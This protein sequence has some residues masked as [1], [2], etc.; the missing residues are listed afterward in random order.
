MNP[1]ANKA[2]IPLSATLNMSRLSTEITQFSGWNSIN[3]PYYGKTISPLYTKN[4]ALS[5]S[6]TIFDGSGNEYVVGSTGLTKN[7]TLVMSYN[8]STFSDSTIDDCIAAAPLSSGNMEIVETATVGLYNI[9][10]GTSSTSFQIYLTGKTIAA[11]CVA[12]G[13]YVIVYTSDSNYYYWIYNG[14]TPVTGEI[15]WVYNPGTTQLSWS[16]TP[17]NVRINAALVSSTW[18]ISILS[19]SGTNITD[20]GFFDIA[21]SQTSGTYSTSWTFSGGPITTEP[22]VSVGSYGFYA[23]FIT[24][25]TSGTGYQPNFQSRTLILSLS[26]TYNKTINVYASDSAHMSKASAVVSTNLIGSISPGASSASMNISRATYADGTVVDAVNRSFVWI[27]TTG[28]DVDN[29]ELSYVY[30]IPSSYYGWKVVYTTTTVTSTAKEYS[31]NMSTYGTK[32]LNPIHTPDVIFDDGYLYNLGF[33]TGNNAL[34]G[35]IPFKCSVSSI[36]LSTSTAI[37]YSASSYYSWNFDNTSSNVYPKS[38]VKTVLDIGEGFMRSNICASL[39][40]NDPRDPSVLSVDVIVCYDSGSDQVILNP[41]VNTSYRNNAGSLFQQ[42]SFRLLYTNGVPAGISYGTEGYRGTLLSEWYS[43]SSLF[44]FEAS[45][46]SATYKNAVDGTIHRI[47]ISTAT[48]SYQYIKNRYIVI[49][50][51]SFINCYDIQTGKALHYAEDFN[52]RVLAGSTSRDDIPSTITDTIQMATGVNLNYEITKSYI[53]SIG[54]NPQQ[55][56]LIIKDHE[57]FISCRTPESNN[58]YDVDIYYGT[59]TDAYAYYYSSA[60]ITSVTLRYISAQLKGAYSPITSSGNVL[61]TPNIFAKYIRSYSNND[62]IVSN[63]TGYPLS[64]SGTT[65]VLAYYLLSGLDGVTDLF[66]IQSMYYAIVDSKI[67]KLTYDSG[68]IASTSAIADVTGMQYIGALPDRA[69]FFSIMNRTIYSFTG[70]CI[71]APLYEANK[72]ESVVGTWYNTATQSLYISTSAGLY[73]INTTSMYMLPIYS[74]IAIY[75]VGSSSIVV[76]SSNAEYISYYNISGYTKQDINISTQMYGAGNEA[77]SKLDSWLIRLYDDGTPEA[78]TVTVSQLTLTDSGYVTDTRTFSIKARD[79]DASTNTLYLRYQ[80]KYQSCVGASL[81]ISSSFAISS[82]IASYS[83][84]T[85]Q[86]SHFNI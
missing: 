69:L 15:S 2:T 16:G 26:S 38:Y 68:V 39:E 64:Y 73:V 33:F 10:N 44:D 30:M 12:P 54:I 82:I 49:N 59:S 29:N 75:F 42:G 48:P 57:T 35:C 6:S 43:V 58:I 63:G 86:I 53:T 74:V 61:Y 5:S 83:I 60:R 79:W 56:S 18:M 1:K 52:N 11:K 32:T 40:T 25:L 80:P 9:V 7:G 85:E 50:T 28:T 65:P 47:D 71:L 78:G 13:L 23:S 31:I 45:S 55:L 17:N 3:S 20:I 22:Y 51:T 67:I 84:D 46:T 62:M 76:T 70:D 36:T 14:V 37:S 24:Q 8:N 72:I 66:V 19:D 41:G 21:Y 27:S 4:E 81:S 34:S 77:V